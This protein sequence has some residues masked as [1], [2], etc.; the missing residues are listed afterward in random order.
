[1][2]F[3]MV[4][5]RLR[6][7]L[8]GQGLGG[9]CGLLLQAL[10][11]GGDDMGYKVQKHAKGSL[12]SRGVEYK[13]GGHKIIEIGVFGAWVAGFRLYIHKGSGHSQTC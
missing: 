1:M 9:L 2:G 5:I 8:G 6:G 7:L 10:H 13:M 11:Q 3:L 4:T 12:G